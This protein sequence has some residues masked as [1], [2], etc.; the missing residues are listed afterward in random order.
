MKRRAEESSA[1]R[2]QESSVHPA[3][4]RRLEYTE[5]DKQLAQL[6]NDL[7]DEVKSTRIKAAAGLVRALKGAEPTRLHEAI[8]RLVRG[9]CS[10]RKASRSGFFVAL[11]EVLSLSKGVDTSASDLSPQSLITRIESLTEPESTS[12]NRVRHPF[13]HVSVTILTILPGEA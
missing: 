6:Y 4:K 12:N 10:S 11:I 5:A 8:T 9:L 3:R 13:I 2:E 7:S 1:D